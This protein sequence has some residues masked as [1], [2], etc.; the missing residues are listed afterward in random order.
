M[1]DD[2]VFILAPAQF[3]YTAGGWRVGS[4][5]P[6]FN[7]RRGRGHPISEPDVIEALKAKGLD[8]TEIAWLM[9]SERLSYRVRQLVSAV[10]ILERL[11]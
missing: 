2:S 10:K 5:H 3:W 4:G 8:E 7:G 1:D 11:E 6:S 9:R